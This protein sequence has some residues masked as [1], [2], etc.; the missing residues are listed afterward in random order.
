MSELSINLVEAPS[1]STKVRCKIPGNGVDSWRDLEFTATFEVLDEKQQDDMPITASKRDWLRRV[2]V[3]VDG[4]PEGKTKDG[5]VL[6]PVDVVIHN[7]FTSDA[8]YAVYQLRTSQNGRE[9]TSMEAMKAG[10]V[11]GNSSRSPQR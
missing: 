2:L 11:R 1:F 8:A 6:S 5:A 9:I 7:Q 10:T 4:I 3:K